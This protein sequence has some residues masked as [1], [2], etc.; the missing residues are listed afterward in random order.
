MMIVCTG[1]LD[2]AI[3]GDVLSLLTSD[4]LRDLGIPSLGHRL[5]ILKMVYQLKMSQNLPIEDGSWVPQGEFDRDHPF[6]CPLAL[7][8]KIGRAH[9]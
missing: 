5:G 7:R 2:Q 9:V 6:A 3:T 8:D 1:C 4:D